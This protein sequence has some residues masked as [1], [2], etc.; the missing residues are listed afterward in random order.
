MALAVLVACV[1]AALTA[2]PGSGRTSTATLVGAGDIAGCAERASS[3]TARLLGNIPGTVYTL[4]DNVQGQ[5]DSNEFKNCYDPT[6][7]KYKKR[8]KPSVGNHEYITAGARPYYNY[9]GWRAGKPG[10]GY[11]SYDRG[12]WHIV[13]LNSNCNQV[14]GCERRSAQ[15][16]WLRRD[17][18]D[19]R[20]RCTLAYFHHPLYATGMNTPTPQVRP[21]W[22]MLHD[23]RAD[24][25]LN[26]HAHRYERHA[27]MT[28]SG[29]RS[30]NGIRQ[31]VVGTGGAD[32]GGEIYRSQAPNLQRVE[33]GTPG[34]L[35]LGLR[36]ESYAWKFVPIAGKSFTDSGT[37][38]C[39]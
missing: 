5:G 14:G 9:F 24:V 25:I 8:T 31:F 29:N 7:G 2:G 33:V 4:G 26:G 36:A 38:S 11:Y 19:H 32:G 16:R 37:T 20:S 6:W 12:S 23:R 28:P 21:L 13:V 35:K 17:L 15:G 3:A 10:R 27:P 34:V 39:H 30:A 1:A 22:R 18:A